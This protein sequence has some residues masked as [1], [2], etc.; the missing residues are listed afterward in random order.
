VAYGILTLGTIFR[1][2]YVMERDLR[3]KLS[4][5]HPAECDQYMREMYKLAVTGLY[6]IFESPRVPSTYMFH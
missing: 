5:R 1:G 2:F 6:H 4:Q 3:P